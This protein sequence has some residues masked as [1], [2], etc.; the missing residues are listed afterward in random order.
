MLPSLVRIVNHHY[1][2]NTLIKVHFMTEC[3]YRNK[4]KSKYQ[5]RF[6]KGIK[7]TEYSKA[8]RKLNTKTSMKCK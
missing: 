5:R 6:L 7:R 1:L 2:K 4:T 8:L 3:R